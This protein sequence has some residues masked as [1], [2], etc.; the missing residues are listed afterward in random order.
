MCHHLYCPVTQDSIWRQFF[1]RKEAQPKSTL[2]LDSDHSTGLPPVCSVG[3][4]GRDKANGL[5][6][7]SFSLAWRV[8]FRFGCQ[9][10]T[11]GV[12][13]MVEG[14]GL[15][16]NTQSLFLGSIFNQCWALWIWYLW[17]LL[18]ITFSGTTWWPVLPG[19]MRDGYS[20]WGKNSLIDIIKLLFG[21]T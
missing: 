9:G 13:L 19:P 15:S 2:W 12:V 7:P 8:F 20:G 3:G 10:G 5:S 21:F 11:C 18:P 17:S 14:L 16:A 1:L 6:A 4:E